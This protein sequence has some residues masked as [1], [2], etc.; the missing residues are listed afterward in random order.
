[1]VHQSRR[2]GITKNN[3]G[4]GRLVYTQKEIGF[5]IKISLWNYGKTETYWAGIG[6]SIW[7]MIPK[8]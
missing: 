7:I 4:A 3:M 5:F 1:M 2:L 6:L 8:I